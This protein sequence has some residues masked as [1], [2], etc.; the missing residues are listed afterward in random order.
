MQTMIQQGELTFE[1][2]KSNC[3]KPIVDLYQSITVGIRWKQHLLSGKWLQA[4]EGLDELAKLNP[5][6]TNMATVK[7]S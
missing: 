5:Q 2:H 3:M 7:K 6:K 4:I 1:K